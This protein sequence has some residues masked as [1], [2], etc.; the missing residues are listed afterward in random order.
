MATKL[1][2]NLRPASFRGVPFH[3]EDAGAG[4]GRRAEVHSYPQR[5]KPWVEDLGRAARE[6]T[7]EAFVIGA[8]Y[9]EQA[10]RLLAALEEPG[11]GT[12]VH[13]WFGNLTVSLAELA[14]ASFSQQLGQARISMSFVESG[15]LEFPVAGAS[16]AAQSRLAASALESA[17][18]AD[19]SDTFDVNGYQDFVAFQAAADTE[20]AIKAT[21]GSYMSGLRELPLAERSVGALA[22]A[23]AQIR[24][25][26][27]M[28]QALVGYLGLSDLSETRKSW[29]NL[30]QSLVS[31]AEDLSLAPPEP[32]A[33]YTPSR[34][35]AWV[36]TT[37]INAL[38]R[39][40]LLAQAVGASTLAQADVYEDTVGLRNKLCT[41]L[42]SEAL[43]ATDRSYTALAD[44]RSKVWQDLTARARDGARLTTITP[45]DTTPSLVL[46]YDYY[47]DATRA[48]DIVARNRVRHPGFVPPTPLHVLTR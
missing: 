24:M 29:G 26:G 32:P 33:V 8:D 10:K 25:P 43:N 45:P 4:V 30:A 42:D 36:N 2:S 39:Q 14:R 7:V 5:D 47:E 41:A 15:E 20:A 31:L 6:F 46:A 48:S 3:V 38:M 37:A 28:G 18:L 11:P 35:Q 44:A 21:V 12:L 27:A 13:P 23:L 16:T 34:Q 40:G 17:A 19:F 22:Q 1:S 9:V